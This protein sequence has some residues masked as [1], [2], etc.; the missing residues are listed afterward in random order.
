MEQND[1]MTRIAEIEKQIA[2]LPA[3]TISVK[4]ISGKKYS[5]HRWTENKKRHEKYIPADE[6]DTLR[7]QIE[8]RKTLE[9]EL[10]QLRKRIP[11]K[12]VITAPKHDFITNVRLGEFLRTFAAPVIKY[13]KRECYQRLYDYIWR[14]A[15]QGFY[16]LRTAQNR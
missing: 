14:A 4:Q 16:Y 8:L 15:G 1:V 5:Y 12:K 9:S 7:E 11:T 3:G 6:A 2:V 13:K 10:K